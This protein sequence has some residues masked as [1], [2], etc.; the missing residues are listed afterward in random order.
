MLEQQDGHVYPYPKRSREVN[1]KGDFL[2][3]SRDEKSVRQRINWMEATYREKPRRIFS[4]CRLIRASIR[5]LK[6]QLRPLSEKGADDAVSCF[7]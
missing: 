5:E 2:M 3:A 6:G 7:V 4:R 1:F